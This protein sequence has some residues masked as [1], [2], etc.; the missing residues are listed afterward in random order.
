MDQISHN[1]LRQYI[2]LALIILLGFLLAKELWP[3]VNAFL[4]AFTLYALLR[5]P[6]LVMGWK[7]NWPRWSAA[8]SLMLASL[9]IIVFPFIWLFRLVEKKLVVYLAD[10]A[11]LN[12]NFARMQAYVQEKFNFDLNSININEQL[13]N[14]A[15]KYATN[16]IGGTLSGISTL[17]IAYFILYFMLTNERSF[18]NWFRNNLPLK[19]NNTHQ[20]EKEIKNM[21]LSNAI[22]I[23]VLAIVQGLIALIGYWIF[24]V[25]DAFLWAVITAICSVVPLVGT[26]LAY[27]PLGI[28]LLA[29]G[30]QSHGIG[31]L[32]YGFV[33]IG[34]CDNIIRFIMQKKLANVHPL[35]TVFGIIVGVN[36]FGFMGLV[37]GPLLISLFIL[38]IKIYNDEFNDNEQLTMNNEQ[39]DEHRLSEK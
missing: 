3:M 7:W 21:V 9:F 13:Q 18:E 26:M 29:T 2:I 25:P 33:V 10:T 16:I 11:T 34:S 23:P 17:V 24:G 37:F 5:K 35:I 6:M 22:G 28:Y 15:T 32:I 36:I 39:L 8:L 19:K 38:L 31:V 14:G 1:R 27:V 4:G 20:V 30:Q 12:A